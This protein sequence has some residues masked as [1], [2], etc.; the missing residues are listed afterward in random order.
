MISQ[1]SGLAA[2][3]LAV[4]AVVSTVVL[5]AFY[6]NGTDHVKAFSSGPP[7]GYSGAPVENSCTDCHGSFP[8]NSGSG[9]VEILGIPHDYK[10]GQQ[11]TVSVK[12]SQEDAILYGFEVT[13]INRLG[14][15]AGTLAV[16]NATR[17]QFDEGP[18]GPNNLWRQYIFHTLDRDYPKRFR[19]KH[20]ELYLDGTGTKNGQ[21]RFLCCR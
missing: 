18:V 7:F 15:Q 11:Y 12:V 6:W 19:F 2:I 20:M 5:T 3:K 10:P 8:V 16:T 9:T 21:D 1:K 13:A 4:I 14:T 17:T